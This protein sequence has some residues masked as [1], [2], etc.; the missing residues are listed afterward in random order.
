MCI[1]PLSLCARYHTAPSPYI[2]GFPLI[3]SSPRSCLSVSLQPMI[4]PFT[5]HFFVICINVYTL[6]HYVSRVYYCVRN[7]SIYL[8]HLGPIEIFLDIFELSE[9]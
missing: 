1:K 7:K 6:F 4:L 2:G 3:N 9:L 5:T 8:F